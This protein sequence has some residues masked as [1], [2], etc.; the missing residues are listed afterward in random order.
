LPRAIAATFARRETEIPVQVPDALTVDF[1]RD[2]TKVRQWNAFVQ[3]LTTVPESLDQV[4][5][6]LS[7]FLMASAEKARNLQ[8]SAS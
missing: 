1:A 7:K 3:N 4:V 2:E 6:D 5:A 8:R